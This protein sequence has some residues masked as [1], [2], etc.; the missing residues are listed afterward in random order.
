MSNFLQAVTNPAVPFIRYALWAG[1]LSG[2]GFGMVGSLVVVKR[3]TYIAGAISHAILAG[4]GFVIFMNEVHGTNILPL[5]GAIA[6][7]LISALIIA[8]VSQKKQE[9][10]DTIIGTIWA[11]GMALGLIFIAK[12][13]G[14]LDPMSYLFGNILLLTKSDI[15]LIIT[16]DILVVISIILFYNQFQA[17]AFD[18]EFARARGINTGFFEIYL[19]LLTALTVVLMVT[20]VGIVMVIALLTIP[21]AVADMLTRRLWKM[22]LLSI[23]FCML[24]NTAGLAVS[25]SLDFPTGPTTIVLAGAVYLLL[26]ILL[27]RKRS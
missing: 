9:R 7:A 8:L 5:V 17:I 18:E 20:T 25:Y 14:Y 15:T 22:M 26:K 10:A 2:A 6:A 19:I 23:L 4:L 27:H 21:A 3:I 1:I 13:P 12:T 24:F 16:L 11:V